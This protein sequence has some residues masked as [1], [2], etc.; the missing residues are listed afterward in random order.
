MRFYCAPKAEQRAACQKYQSITTGGA[1]ARRTLHGQG[2]GARA[3]LYFISNV[4]FSSRC[5]YLFSMRFRASL[6]ECC[7]CWRRERPEDDGGATWSTQRD[8]HVLAQ[9]LMFYASRVAVRSISS[10]KQIQTGFGYDLSFNLKPTSA[11]S[12]CGI[13]SLGESKLEVVNHAVIKF[14]LSSAHT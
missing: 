6:G 8:L 2:E 13:S 10:K 4:F 3:T 9:R 7:R 12:S 11:S 1:V 5:F 14:S